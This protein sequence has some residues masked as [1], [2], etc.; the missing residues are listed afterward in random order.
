MRL[1]GDELLL[2]IARCPVVRHCLDA[3]ASG[4]RCAAVI[5]A[6]G[7]REPLQVPEPWNGAIETAPLLFVCWNPSWNPHERFP[8][9]EWADTQIIEFF[10]TRFAHS[11]ERSR[12]WQEI[13]AIASRLLARTAAPGIDFAV[14]DAVR[15]KS[16]AGAGAPEA[17]AECVPR[18]LGRT[19]GIS[20]ARVIVALGRDARAAVATHFGVPPEIGVHQPAGGT[21]A[22]LIALLGAPGSSQRR[23][24]TAAELCVVAAALA[25]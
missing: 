24:L 10:R 16:R 3:S 20:A 11:D 25:A 19:L 13:G 21:S 15:C 17:V 4:H 14:T 12:T 22:P 2:E 6:Q 5:A 8:T 23:K 9:T 18:Y 1:A 7:G